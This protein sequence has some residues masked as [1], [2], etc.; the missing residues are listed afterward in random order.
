MPGF[1]GGD[2]RHLN[3]EKKQ[4]KKSIKERRREKREKKQQAGE[5][6]RSIDTS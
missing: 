4:P 1:K 2:K 6:L 5:P 3:R